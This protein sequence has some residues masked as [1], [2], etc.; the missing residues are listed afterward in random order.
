MLWTKKLWFDSSHRGPL[1]L[2]KSNRLVELSTVLYHARVPLDQGTL[3]RKPDHRQTSIEQWTLSPRTNWVARL[4]RQFKTFLI[5]QCVYFPF[6]FS[7]VCFVL[8]KVWRVRLMCWCKFLWKWCKICTE[9]LYSKCWGKKNYTDRR[10]LTL[11]V[12]N[13][14]SQVML[15]GAFDAQE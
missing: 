12:P 5:K 15:Q 2:E 7:P 13:F 11:S 9:I 8:H 4:H 14:V 3:P 6:Q 10:C 1:E